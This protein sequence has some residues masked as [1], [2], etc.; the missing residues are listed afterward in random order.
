MIIWITFGI[1]LAAIISMAIFYTGKLQISGYYYDREECYE[2]PRYTQVPFSTKEKLGILF[3][4]LLFIFLCIL[5][6]SQIIWFFK[7]LLGWIFYKESMVD[8]FVYPVAFFFIFLIL[9]PLLIGVFVIMPAKV[10]QILGLSI[11]RFIERMN[12][13][14]RL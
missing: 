8:F 10:L 9:P 4:S 1:Y 6:S 3:V 14:R 7:I 12:G 11:L 5:F 2:M 13:R